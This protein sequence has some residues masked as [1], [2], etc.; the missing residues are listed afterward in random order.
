MARRAL[1]LLQKQQEQSQ[2]GRDLRHTARP[3]RMP[4]LGR[5]EVCSR[6]A[7]LPARR[8]PRAL[9]PPPPA[10]LR[11]RK[12]QSAWGGRVE[13]KEGRNPVFAV[14]LLKRC[15]ARRF[16]ENVSGFWTLSRNEINTFLYPKATRGSR[17]GPKA[18][19]L[20][21]CKFRTRRRHRRE[22]S[23][24][25]ALPVGRLMEGKAALG[26]EAVP[27][28]GSPSEPGRLRCPGMGLASCR[29]GWGGLR[30]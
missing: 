29:M 17:L 3:L 9:A 22:G 27:G 14:R 7:F 20:A 21:S 25:S 26:P 1:N 6:A 18:P 11:C 2:Q 10:S 23:A 28:C 13:V 30:L 19:I 8:P 15:E 16:R 24:G 12:L 4:V 5:S